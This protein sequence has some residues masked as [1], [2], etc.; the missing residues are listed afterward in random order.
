M[1]ISKS[2]GDKVSLAILHSTFQNKKEMDVLHADNNDCV[3]C[4]ADAFVWL[5][6]SELHPRRSLKGCVIEETPTTPELD[7]SAQVFSFFTVRRS[8]SI[9]IRN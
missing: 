5:S 3:A 2:D 4:D 7:L 9:K 6:I 1:C 8:K